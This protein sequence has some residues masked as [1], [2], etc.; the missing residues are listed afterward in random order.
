M[1]EHQK[2]EQQKLDDDAEL[3][4]AALTLEQFELRLGVPL[5]NTGLRPLSFYASQKHPAG[6]A[7]K[8]KVAATAKAQNACDNVPED[9]EEPQRDYRLHGD[10]RSETGRPSQPKPRAAMGPH[11]RRCNVCRHPDRKAIEHEFLRWRSPDK[12]AREYGIPDHSSIYRHVH[13]T[14]IFARRRKAV[15]VALE[16]VIECAEVVKV[17]ASS[18]VKAVHAY[19]HINEFGEWIKHPTK[20]IVIVQHQNVSQENAQPV[21]KDPTIP[22]NCHPACPDIGRDRSEGSVPGSSEIALPLPVSCHPVNNPRS[23]L[24]CHPACPDEGREHSE[25]SALAFSFPS[26]ASA[27]TPVLNRQTQELEHAPTH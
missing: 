26:A 16:S 10:L 4:R 14:G 8:T 23:P 15:R 17:T 25:G 27:E 7:E 20:H 19:T 5:T 13:A 6:R 24:P 12:I 1:D 11:T 22:T 3:V 18:L 21:A 2:D 9:Q